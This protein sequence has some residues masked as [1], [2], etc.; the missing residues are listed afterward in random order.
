MADN[1]TDEQVAEMAD[2]KRKL[3]ARE[4]RGGYDGSLIIIKARIQE[5]ESKPEE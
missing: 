1:L 2:L 5:L 3:R 4:R